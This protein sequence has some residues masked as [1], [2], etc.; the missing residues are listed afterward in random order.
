MFRGIFQVSS[1][2][3]ELSDL[4]DA[5]ATLEESLNDRRSDLKYASQERYI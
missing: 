2:E 4:K 3:V 5:R 1:A